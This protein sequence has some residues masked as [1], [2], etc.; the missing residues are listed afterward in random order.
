MILVPDRD[1]IEWTP[2]T[3]TSKA[4]VDKDNIRVELYSVTPNLKTYQ[5][6]LL[7]D[8]EWK[9]VTST[10]DIKLKNGVNEVMFRSENLAGVHGPEHRVKIK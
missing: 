7:P 10:I 4:K 6:K 5:M 1:A 3:I 9:S 2:N 8:G